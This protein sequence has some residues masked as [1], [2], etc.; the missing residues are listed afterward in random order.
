MAVATTIGMVVVACCAARAPGVAP[1]EDEVDLEAGKLRRQAWEAIEVAV[2]R[3]VLDED[4]L[5]LDIT[6]IALVLA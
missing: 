5:T 3:P 1:H 2:R 6:K 4:V